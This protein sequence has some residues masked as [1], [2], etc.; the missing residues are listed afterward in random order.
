MNNE[1]RRF[2]KNR[3]FGNFLQ[4][5]PNGATID[6]LLSSFRNKEIGLEIEYDEND[7]IQDII[8]FTEIGKTIPNLL[9]I[10]EKPRSFV[11]SLE[12]KIPVDLVKKINYKAVASLSR[13]SNDWEARTLVSVNPKTLLSDVFDETINIYENRFIITLVDKCWKLIIDEKNRLEN[14]IEHLDTEYSLTRI[15]ELISSNTYYRTDNKDILNSIQSY[16]QSDSGVIRSELA[17]QL[18]E[19]KRIFSRLQLIRRSNFYNQLHKQKRVSNPVNK[20]NILLFDADYNK[21]YKLWNVLLS[22][23]PDMTFDLD[24]VNVMDTNKHFTLYVFFCLIVSI[25]NL[26]FKFN[27]R[28]LFQIVDESS[29][30]GTSI[31]FY[32]DDLTILTQIENESIEIHIQGN[33]NGAIQ[34]SFRIKTFDLEFDGKSMSEID[35]LTKNVLN[36]LVSATKKGKKYFP[37]YGIVSLDIHSCSD[38]NDFG[39]KLYRRF[40]NIGDNFSSEENP[41]DLAKWNEYKHGLLIIKPSDIRINVLRLSRM[42]NYYLLKSKPIGS[43][44]SSCPICSSKNIRETGHD[45]FVCND[46]YHRISL[47]SC[48]NCGKKGFLWIRYLDNRFLNDPE[49][50]KNMSDQPYYFM[51]KRYEAIMGKYAIT[52]FVLEKDN[53]DWKLKSICPKCGVKLGDIRKAT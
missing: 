16:E 32:E 41:Q 37:Q 47:S 33:A 12:E 4:Q 36:N 3:V 24:D 21:A 19:I 18:S 27:E 43:F 22:L 38:R 50:T 45:E 2:L 20:T 10:I 28:A 25:V 53:S 13:D 42:L 52:S 1:E 51:L 39:D 11:R 48:S 23:R 5:Y 15:Q 31:E 26:G 34:E 7:E 30:T 14:R 49:I 29:F 35:Y 6:Q 8:Y 44:K 46:C 9:K 40:F 17:S